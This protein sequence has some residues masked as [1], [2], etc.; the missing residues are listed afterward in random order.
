MILKALNANVVSEEAGQL[1]RTFKTYFTVQGMVRHVI[2][3]SGNCTNVASTIMM[4]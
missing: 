1:E 2:M 4:E 3:D